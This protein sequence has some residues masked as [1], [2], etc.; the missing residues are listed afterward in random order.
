M[1]KGDSIGN[2]FIGKNPPQE[3]IVEE[4][5]LGK[6]TID[7]D[8][9]LIFEDI[10]FKDKAIFTGT[11]VKKIINCSMTNNF[12]FHYCSKLVVNR[13]NLPFLYDGSIKG[14][15]PD[16]LS[17]SGG[18]VEE[19]PF[20]YL[21]YE[22]EFHET[23]TGGKI[24]KSV[25]SSSFL[26]N[27]ELETSYESFLSSSCVV[28][29]NEDGENNYVFNI[30]G[31]TKNLS[32]GFM[33]TTEN[34]KP[35]SLEVWS[36]KSSIHKDIT[37]NGMFLNSQL[38]MDVKVKN[39]DEPFSF[40]HKLSQKNKQEAFPEIVWEGCE[41]RIKIATDMYRMNKNLQ[42]DEFLQKNNNPLI[43]Y[44]WP[45]YAT[46][47]ANI[48]SESNISGS[49]IFRDKSG[50]EHYLRVYG[51]SNG[52]SMITLNNVFKDYVGKM[53]D[54]CFE[55]NGNRINIAALMGDYTYPDS[56]E[57]VGF[58]NFIYIYAFPTMTAITYDNKVKEWD[59]GEQETYII[60]PNYNYTGARD[61]MKSIKGKLF[62]ETSGTP[63]GATNI[64]SNI[65]DYYITPNLK[66]T[67]FSFTYDLKNFP[68]INKESIEF[69]I[70]NINPNQMYTSTKSIINYSKYCPIFNNKDLST[71]YVKIT[72]VD[73]EEKPFVF[74]EELVEGAITLQNYLTTYKPMLTVNLVDF[75]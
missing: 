49:T 42:C 20:P 41:E 19:S 73:K 59:F 10:D 29:D 32:H 39:W 71:V 4:N 37:A 72:N 69:T 1:P 57:K 28:L 68:N 67:S 11:D 70:S 2:Y 60:M 30:T 23:Y 63:F 61:T 7:S 64:Q 48:F 74:V 65:T 34:G 45:P 31:G 35:Y 50:Q 55:G 9:G 54:I 58:K 66:N 5:L 38:G 12:D 27:S 62:I 40:F 16:Y 17:F 44:L 22:G 43:Q 8:G 3:N 18:K 53:T 15:L 14:S 33:P 46:D 75:N 52:N 25:I 47:Y 24:N 21:N 51:K 6:I 36:K 13:E 26:N 56:V